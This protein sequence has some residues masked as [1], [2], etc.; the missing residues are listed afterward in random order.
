MKHRITRS[1][2]L[3]A[4]LST[5]PIALYAA[6][7]AHMGGAT[8]ITPDNLK[9]GDAPPSLP[10]GAKLAV[11][12]GDPSKEGPF[13]FRLKLPANFKVAPHTHPAD[14]MVTVL[15]GSPSVGLGDKVDTKA[16]HALKPG[17]FHFLPGKTSHY[18]IMKSPT[19]LQVQGTGPFGLN[20]VNEADD[21]Q[22]MAAKK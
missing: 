21:P 19:E 18:W 20:Y 9:W 17:S 14:Y 22:K 1:A 12:H 4:A 16:V 8:M 10:K 3:L 5:V 7:S 11:L 6:D 2:L 15:S 13:A